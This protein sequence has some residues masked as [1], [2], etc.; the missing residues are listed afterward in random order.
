MQAF[1]SGQPNGAQIAAQGLAGGIQASKSVG[2]VSVSYQ[3]LT[4]LE[5]WGSWQLTS[6]GQQLA[7]AAK[8]MG[9]GPMVVY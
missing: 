1:T 5:E 4:S 7:T 8:V 6:Y 2:D 9:A 3:V